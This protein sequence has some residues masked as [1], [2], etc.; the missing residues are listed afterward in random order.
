MAKHYLAVLKGKGL[1]I[2]LLLLGIFFLILGSLGGGGEAKEAKTDG[3]REYFEA[4][5]A[6]R[7][8]L[9]ARLAVL[10]ESVTGVSDVLVLITLDTGEEAVYG[11]NRQGELIAHKMPAVRG[12]AVVCKGGGDIHT[13]ASL[14]TLLS[15]TLGIGSH[16]ISVC[17]R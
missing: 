6:Y 12:V 7:A 5:E 4:A 11:G 1:F 10:C 15:S 16:R 3:T 8:D 17:G 2:V 9:E 14:I 13:R